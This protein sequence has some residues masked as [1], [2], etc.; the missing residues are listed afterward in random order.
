MADGVADSEGLLVGLI[1]P[2]IEGVRVCVG[3][4]VLEAEPVDVLVCVRERVTVAVGDTVAL[5]VTL[6]VPLALSVILWLGVNERL[7][8]SD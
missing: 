5:A 3:V 1:E 2:V 7:A 8:L 6:R 4:P